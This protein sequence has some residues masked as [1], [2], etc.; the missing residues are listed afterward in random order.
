MMERGV[1]GKG[2]CSRYFTGVARECSSEGEGGVAALE[3]GVS[4]SRQTSAVD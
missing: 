3:Q 1:E 2:G 4:R